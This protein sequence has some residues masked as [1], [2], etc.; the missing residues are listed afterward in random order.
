MGTL[1]LRQKHIPVFKPNSNV[2]LPNP[3]KNLLNLPLTYQI[4]ILKGEKRN[5]HELGFLRLYKKIQT[6]EE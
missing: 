4:K 5:K 1:L 6:L 3:L 2:V